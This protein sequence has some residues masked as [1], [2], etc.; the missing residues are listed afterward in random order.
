MMGENLYSGDCLI[1]IGKDIISFTLDRDTANY[2]KLIHN[3]NMN[4]K[5]VGGQ[6]IISKKKEEEDL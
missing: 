3:E 1:Q 2:L 6:P 4:W 5:I